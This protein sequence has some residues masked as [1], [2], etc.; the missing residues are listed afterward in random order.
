MRFHPLAGAL[1]GV[2][3]AAFAA[4]PALALTLHDNGDPSLGYGVT[5][6]SDVATINQVGDTFTLAQPAVLQQV[7][8]WGEQGGNDFAIRIFELTGGIPVATPIADVSATVVGTPEDFFGQMY[9]HYVATLPDRALAAGD[10]ALSIVGT[11]PSYWFWA[12]SCE[13]GCEG[14]SWRRETDGQAWAAGNFTFAYLLHGSGAGLAAPIADRT[15]APRVA[16]NPF[17]AATSISFDVARRTH[18][19]LDV[20]DVGGRVVRRLL[21]GELPAGSR[22][23]T[24]NGADDRGQRVVAGAYLYRLSVD[25]VETTGRIVRLR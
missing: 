15:D 11:N 18:V 14:Q 23:V 8:W 22:A 13:D 10:Y 21:H 25:G 3:V 6:L 5:I 12:A 24:W 20:L 4:A 17:R 2:A 19:S 9:L 16:P 7:E 1:A